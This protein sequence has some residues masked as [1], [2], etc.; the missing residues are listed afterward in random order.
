MTMKKIIAFILGVVLLSGCASMSTMQTARTTNEGEVGYSFGGGYVSTEMPIEDVDTLSINAPM[1][2]VG[3]RYGVNDKLDVGGKI[4]IIGTA[5]ADAKYQFLGDKE[6]KV[7]GSAGFGIGYLSMESG[8]TKSNLYDLMVPAYF[9]YHPAEWLSFY[10]SPKYVFRLN[11]Y[12]SGEETGS[13]AS[14]WYGAGAG[15]R[16]G[17]KTGV[18]IEYTYF[19]NT[20][21]E[22]PFSQIN[23]GIGIR[24]K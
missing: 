24:I 14:H 2:E 1:L 17:K 16:I 13:E 22:D 7:A 18:F 12:D 8:D 3:A 9:S 5:V 15:M 4:T 20:E 6:S 10:T 21:Y 11:A 23:A 19:G